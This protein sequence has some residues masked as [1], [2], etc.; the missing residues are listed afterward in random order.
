MLE[1]DHPSDCKLGEIAVQL[2]LTDLSDAPQTVIDFV[3]V[4]GTQVDIFHHVDV[5]PRYFLAIVSSLLLVIL[6]V[7][8]SE[9]PAHQGCVPN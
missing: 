5:L 8:S 2:F 1:L 3:Q 4:K 9:E 6:D 7:L